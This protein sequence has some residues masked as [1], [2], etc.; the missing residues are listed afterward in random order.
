MV[1]ILHK[2]WK[3]NIQVLCHLPLSEDNQLSVFS[4]FNN[5]DLLQIA[6]NESICSVQK[7]IDS[8]SFITV[9]KRGVNKEL[10]NQQMNE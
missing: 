8:N 2:F 6:L 7:V 3:F 1:H 5:K 9:P 4:F 10:L